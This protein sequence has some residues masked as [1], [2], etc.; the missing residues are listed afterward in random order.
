MLNCLLFVLAWIEVIFTEVDGGDW[1]EAAAKADANEG[2]EIL[3][4]CGGC[5]TGGGD[6]SLV[7]GSTKSLWVVWLIL[8]VWTVEFLLTDEGI[9]GDFIPDGW[10]WE[11]LGTIWVSIDFFRDAK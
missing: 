4:N 11:S 6:T 2:P 3:V 1:T 10:C 9:V 7:I 8:T 5:E